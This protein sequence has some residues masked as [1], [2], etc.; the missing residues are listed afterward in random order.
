MAKITSK[1]DARTAD[2]NFI[3]TSPATE[4]TLA[5]IPGLSIPEHDYI[6]LGYTDDNLTQVVYKMGGS[7]GEIVATLTLVYD[8]D[9][10]ISITKL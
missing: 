4:G 10:L 7:D 1:V 2:V 8:G 3:P 9:K 5:K 6:S